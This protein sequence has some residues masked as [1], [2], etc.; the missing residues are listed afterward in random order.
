MLATIGC[1]SLEDLFADV[2]EQ[3]RFPDMD[4]PHPLS[5]LEIQRELQ[6]LANSNKGIE[7]GS[8][9]LGAGAYNH[10]IPAIVDDVL[11]RA[12]FYTSYTPYQPELSQ[13]MLQAMLPV[14][15]LLLLSIK[16]FNHA[17]QPKKLLMH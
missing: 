2:P 7:T 10:F 5:E 1:R 4:L 9:F 16:L 6:S 17:F 8:C 12:E 11:G 3:Y 15:W 13:G 14:T